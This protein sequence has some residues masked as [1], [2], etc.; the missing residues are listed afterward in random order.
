MS[1]FKKTTEAGRN[2]YMEAADH[3]W[4][5]WYSFEDPAFTGEMIMTVDLP[6]K[7]K[8]TEVSIRFDDIPEGISPEDNEAGTAQ[9]LKN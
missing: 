8:H 5:Y 6:G 2:T 1:W 4:M 3:G 7:G 9:S